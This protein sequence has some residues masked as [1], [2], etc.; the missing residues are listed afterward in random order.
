MT[1]S[2]VCCSG[3]RSCCFPRRHDRNFYFELNEKM[4]D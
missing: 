3:V 4:I 2:V 1:G